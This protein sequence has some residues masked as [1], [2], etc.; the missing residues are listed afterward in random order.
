VK[1][2]ANARHFF[3]S[4]SGPAL[5]GV[6]P[7][8]GPCCMAYKRGRPPRRT[9]HLPARSGRPVSPAKWKQKPGPPVTRQYSHGDGS[10]GDYK[11][12]RDDNSDGDW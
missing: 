12:R 8:E 7:D 3:K 5:R 6:A 1:I 10:T 2:P 11:R 9:P 4:A